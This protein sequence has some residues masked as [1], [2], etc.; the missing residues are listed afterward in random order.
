MIDAIKNN[1]LRLLNFLEKKHICIIK[2]QNKS[3]KTICRI[4]KEFQKVKERKLQQSK[5]S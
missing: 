4:E 1:N 3:F 2:A 5:Q